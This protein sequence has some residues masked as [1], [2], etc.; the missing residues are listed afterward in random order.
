[1]QMVH[2][3]DKCIEEDGKVNWNKARKL[4]HGIA[5]LSILFEVDNSK[6]QVTFCDQFSN[7]HGFI[8][9]LV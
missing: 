6:P 1:M 7:I 4:K 3:E 8:F 5:I 9:L 2:I